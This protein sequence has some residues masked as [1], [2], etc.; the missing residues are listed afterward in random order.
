MSTQ[1]SAAPLLDIRNL[2]VALAGVPI[3]KG[4]S[5]QVGEGEIVGIV[6]ESGSGKSVTCRALLGLLP[7]YAHVT[8]DVGFAGR[9]LLAMDAAELRSVRGRD[10]SMIFQ[11]PSSHLDPLK[12]IGHHIAEPLRLHERMRKTDAL[13]EAVRI[14]G[15]VEINEPEKRVR[16]YPH[17][18]SGGMKQRAMIGGAIACTPRLLLADEPTTALD[19]TVQAR[20]LDVLRDLN[21]K[22]NLGVILVSHDLAVVA[23]MCHRVVV[24]RQGEI[25]EQGPTRDILFNPQHEY[26]RLLLGSQP[27]RIALPAREAAPAEPREAIFSIENLGVTYRAGGLMSRDRTVHA[28]REVNLEI[29]RGECFGVV[30]ESGS[31]K[32]TMAKALV[33]LAPPSE[34][35]IVF[36]GEDVTALK[37]AP[38]TA[39]RRA[40]QIAFQNPFDSLNPAM[41]VVDSIAEPLVRHRLANWREA[42]KKALDMM[43]QVELPAEFAG[44]RPRQLSGGQ[45]Q[46]VG[47]ARALILE[48]QVLIADEITSAL[49]VTIQAQIIRLLARL[50]EERDLT[51]VYIS[52][53]LDVVRKLCD[54]IAVFRSSRLVETG[55]TQ[56][57]LDRPQSD[58]T[59]LLRNSV[60]RMEAAAP[61]G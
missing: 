27:S 56:S 52:H 7:D 59:A 39:Y 20:I 47:I 23:Q 19:V 6:G 18:L 35:R 15:S 42:R 36:R 14:L 43:R 3:V 58:Y 22:L 31:G 51:I 34:G 44:R 9:D 45:C 41:R 16:A 17:E 11:N 60:P 25:V 24:M 8:G 37:G 40:V 5:F 61:S 50:R 32:S 12:T 4:V 33:K 13:R 48:P 49:D 55:D 2:T 30:G 38:L 1:P 53:D 57:V 28:L 46:R 26:T 10:L 54:R 21:R 29:R